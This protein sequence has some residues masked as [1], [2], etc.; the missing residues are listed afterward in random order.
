MDFVA[1]KYVDGNDLFFFWKMSLN[2][3]NFGLRKKGKKNEKL[4]KRKKAIRV[5]ATG[6]S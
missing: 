6:S 5:H 2:L 4:F 3:N 1:N